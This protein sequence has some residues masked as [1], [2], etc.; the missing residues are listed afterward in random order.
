M[1]EA[2]QICERITGKTLRWSYSETNRVGDHIWWISDLS[3]FKSHYPEWRLEYDV[4][5]IL[6]EIYEANRERWR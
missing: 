2:I 5:A 1:L 3:R 6:R 4:P